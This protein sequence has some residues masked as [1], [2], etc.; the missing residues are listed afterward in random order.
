[1]F[2]EN[3]EGIGETADQSLEC[4]VQG[5]GGGM[6]KVEGW[7][8]NVRWLSQCNCSGLEFLRYEMQ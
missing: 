3:I 4:T 1:M 8:S 6:G 5:L 7:F 2:K